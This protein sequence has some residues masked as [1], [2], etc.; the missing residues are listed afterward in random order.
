MKVFVS[1]KKEDSIEALLITKEFKLQGVETYLDLLDD[2][3]DDGKALTD[4]IK[5]K[6][7]SC[8][9]IIVVMSENTK[10]SWWVPFEIGM[11]AQVDMPTASY[12]T[13]NSDLPSYL[14]YWPRLR[15]ITD[16]K[17]YI[18]IR[19]QVGRRMQSLYE[20]YS[21]A[22]RRKFETPEFYKQLKMELR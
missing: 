22:S 21:I 2:I 13:A 19:K 3:G 16:V 6:L 15:S 4:H 20:G 17:K 10:K 9:D 7:N 1:H 8:T 5:S 11:S 18:D 14:S 12:L